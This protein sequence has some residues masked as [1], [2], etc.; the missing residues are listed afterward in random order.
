MRKIAALALLMAVAAVTA[1]AQAPVVSQVPATQAASNWHPS[2][3]ACKAA[4]SGAGKLILDFQVGLN[5]LSQFRMSGDAAVV[6]LFASTLES[7]AA[8][9]HHLT[10]RLF[11]CSIV[12]GQMQEEDA[13]ALADEYSTLAAALSDITEFGNMYNWTPPDDDE[14]PSDLANA[15]PACGPVIASRLPERIE[16][17]LGSTHSAPSDAEILKLAGE[18]DPSEGQGLTACAGQAYKA[19]YV[20]A[21]WRLLTDASLLHTTELASSAS[22]NLSLIKA[23]DATGGQTIQVQE[24]PRLCTG[25]VENWGWQK[26]IQWN[27]F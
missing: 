9:A 15:A 27:C 5:N 4:V 20:G 7:D 8:S 6:S 17:L 23:L 10:D 25:T 14:L 12:K 18:A 3:Q 1:H 24:G 13:S 11:A 2:P 19:G 26:T 22:Q 21:A 16:K